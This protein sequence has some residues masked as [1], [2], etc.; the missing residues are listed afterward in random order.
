M[1]SSQAGGTK[2][3]FERY[4]RA[5]RTIQSNVYNSEQKDAKSTAIT[6]AGIVLSAWMPALSDKRRPYHLVL[7]GPNFLQQLKKIANM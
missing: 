4:T 5:R 2:N 7:I 1:G 3:S 6:R